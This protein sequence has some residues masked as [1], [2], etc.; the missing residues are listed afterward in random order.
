MRQ[1]VSSLSLRTKALAVGA[2]LLIL[3]GLAGTVGVAQAQLTYFSAEHRADIQQTH[4][5]VAL[6]EQTGDEGEARTVAV[7]N[8][9]EG[10]AG[11]EG[12]LL[13]EDGKLLLGGD[14]SMVPGKT[15]DEKISAQNTS[16]DMGEYV[17]LTVRKY[18]TNEAGD[19]L[20]GLNPELIELDYDKGNSVWV[21]SESESTPERM[22]FYCQSMVPAGTTVAPAVTGIKVLP[23][24]LNDAALKVQAASDSGLRV[25][26]SAQVDSVQTNH[27][28]AA[29]KSAW[30]VDVTALG[31][32]WNGG[33]VA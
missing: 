25:G 3:I 23:A 14:E 9:V 15:Y 12:A 29:A 28:V 1:F 17:R 33:S 6:T 16:A 30:G 11:A 22:V 7:G 24:A 20:P 27:A 13:Q 8:A 32:N 31:L 19:K 18:W 10:T 21:Y 4:L 26:L 2:A 5:G